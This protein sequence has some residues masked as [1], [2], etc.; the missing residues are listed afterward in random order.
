V[1][2]LR[3]AGSNTALARG[4][5]GAD[6]GANGWEVTVTRSPDRRLAG[7]NGHVFE[8]RGRNPIAALDGTRTASGGTGTSSQRACWEKGERGVA[9]FSYLL[10]EVGEVPENTSIQVFHP[11]REKSHIFVEQKFY[12]LRRFG[13]V[14]Q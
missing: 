14:C 8:R 4:Q 5:M 12:I 7:G 13:L 9:S 2:N 6:W 3:R 1:V 11:Y 10:T